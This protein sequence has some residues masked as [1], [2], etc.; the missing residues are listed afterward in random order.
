MRRDPAFYAADI[1]IPFSVSTSTVID[2]VHSLLL[3]AQVVAGLPTLQLLTV[4]KTSASGQGAFSR[5]YVFLVVLFVNCWL[6][7]LGVVYS[8]VSWLIIL[9]FTRNVW[10]TGKWLQPPFK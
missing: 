3:S 8:S 10:G 2:N 9:V 6:F 7:V 5:C 4:D 1:V